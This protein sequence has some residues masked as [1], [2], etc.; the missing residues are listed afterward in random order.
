VYSHN[1]NV[2]CSQSLWPLKESSYCRLC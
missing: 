1:E 2:P